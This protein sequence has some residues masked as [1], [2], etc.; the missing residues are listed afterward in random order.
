MA[1]YNGTGQKADHIRQ[2]A[3]EQAKIK[4]ALDKRRGLTTPEK[5]KQDIEKPKGQGVAKEKK[6]GDAFPLEIFPEPLRKLIQAA[7]PALGVHPD[8]MAAAVLTTTGIA[9]GG[10][11]GLRVKSQTAHKPVFYMALVGLPNSNK[12]GA[13]KLA[14]KPIQ[15][16]DSENYKAYKQAK[17]EYEAIVSI[18]KDERT[19]QGITETPPPPMFKRSIVSDCTPEA[20]ASVHLDNL[21][22]IGV[23]RDELAGWFK[24]FNRYHKGSE[25]EFWL[26]NWSGEPISIDRKTSEPIHI[27]HPCISVVGTVQ[28]GVLEGLAKGERAVNGFADR[29]LFAWPDDVGKPLWTEEEL[30]PHLSAEYT[31]AMQRLMGLDFDG[32]GKPHTVDLGKEAKNTLFDLFNTENKRWCDE[33]TDEMLAG[34]H[35]KFDIH[36]IRL[37]LALHLLDWAYSKEDAPGKEI[38]VDT[39]R[40]AAKVAGYFRRQSLKVYERVHHADPVA[41]LAKDKRAVYEAL[42]DTFRTQAGEEVANMWNMPARTFRL[43]LKSNRGTLFE[44]PARGMWEKVY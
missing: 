9:A 20:L 17:S 21:R 14:L 13:L 42:P 23:H 1:E 22:G 40:N 43:F 33:A 18:S 29:L 26:S 6:G 16:R 38:N 3:F 28:P 39:V 4:A 12:S 25:Q 2:V 36:T 10:T 7:K 27:A 35:G 44:T 19:A 5:I 8:F 37:A 31:Q 41:S 34:I 15:E 11:H 24:D 30:P 32:D